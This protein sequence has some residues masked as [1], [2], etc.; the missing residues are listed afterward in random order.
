MKT[1]LVLLLAVAAV[2]PAAADSTDP[3][4]SDRVRVAT[5]LPFVEDALHL[6]PERVEIV[7]TVRRSLH[8]PAPEGVIDLGN[9][10]S[11]SFERLVQAKPELV[12]GDASIHARLVPRFERLG[13]EV[14]LVDAAG[15]DATFSELARVAARVGAEAEVGQAI[16][17][18]RAELRATALAAP[19]RTLALFGTPGSFFAVTERTWLGDL[20]AQLN[21]ENVG[22]QQRGDE[23]FSGLVALSDEALVT[24]TPQLVLLVAH[25]DPRAIQ[26]ALEQRVAKGGAWRSIRESAAGRFTPARRLRRS[27]PICPKRCRRRCSPARTSASTTPP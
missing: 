21:F 24:M 11:P 8:V 25:G 2:S 23:R 26:G 9:P 22:G 15:V 12:V 20:L 14:L 4:P 16:A 6:A 13:I 17:R 27:P 7:A 3:T 19:T 10:H 5:L 1:W 18:A